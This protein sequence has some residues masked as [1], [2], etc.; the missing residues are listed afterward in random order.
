MSTRAVEKFEATVKI[1][2]KVTVT[3]KKSI[4]GV[5]GPLGKKF[6]SLRKYP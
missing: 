4:L 2:D 3:L 1:P 6:L 5:E